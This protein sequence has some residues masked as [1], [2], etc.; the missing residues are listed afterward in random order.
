MPQPIARTYLSL[1]AFY[2]SD[3]LRRSSPER[4]VGLFWRSLRGQT[5]RAAWVEDTGELYL[6]QHARGEPGGGSVHLLAP[7][8]D[9]RELDRRLLGWRDVCGRPGS[10]EWLLERMGGDEPAPPEPRVR[11]RRRRPVVRFGGP[12]GAAA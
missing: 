4:D 7:E 10:L 11:R 12:A 5:F 2:R 6:F 9:A 1:D 3:S 8:L